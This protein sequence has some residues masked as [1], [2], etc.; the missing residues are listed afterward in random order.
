MAHT[1]PRV[2]S[3]NPEEDGDLQMIWLQLCFLRAKC[4]DDAGA[5]ESIALIADR[6]THLAQAQGNELPDLMY[7][8]GGA[9][10]RA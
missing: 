10:G 8:S 5:L 7:P 3:G 6:L 1:G 2:A 9:L 4:R